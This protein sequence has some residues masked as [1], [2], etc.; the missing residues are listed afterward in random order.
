MTADSADPA[1]KNAA[2]I[3]DLTPCITNPPLDQQS[4]ATSVRLLWTP[5]TLFVRFQCAAKEIY[6]PFTKTNDPLYKADVVELFLDAKG[7]SKQWLEVEVSPNNVVMQM[8]TT[9]T[10]EP[11]SDVNLILNQDIL[12]R[13]FWP[14]PDWT[15][16]GLRT[17]TSIKRDHDVVTGWITDIS[18]PASVTL[19]RLGLTSYAHLTMR[20]NFL[21]YDYPNKPGSIGREL[22][23]TDWAP[24]LLGCPHISPQAMGYLTLDNKTTVSQATGRAATGIDNGN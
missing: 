1:W 12:Q 5:K 14:I 16:A 3:P 2:L 10:A 4:R 24:V 18:L 21:R 11:G 13:D 19:R 6:S 22:I 17:A 23:P 20:A 9:L 15:T 8:M 7:D